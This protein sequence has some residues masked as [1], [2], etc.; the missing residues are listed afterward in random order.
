MNSVKLTLMSFV[1]ATTLQAVVSSASAA[2]MNAMVYKAP[3]AAAVDPWS[4]WQL[5]L[6]ALAVLPDA[7]GSTINVVGAPALSSPNSGIKIDNSVVPELDISYFLNPN[8]S[9]EVVLGVTPHKITGTGTL[10]NL[11]IGKTWL[12]PPTAT[13]QYHFTNFGA[14]QPY[15]GAG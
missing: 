12:L 3:P 8:W 13:L 4:P 11:N 7:G 10:A 1:A 2:D 14:F 15:V 6:R 5:R 9:V